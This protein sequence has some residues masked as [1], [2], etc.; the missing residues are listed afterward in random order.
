MIETAT[1][2]EIDK[3]WGN[4]KRL[5]WGAYS[6]SGATFMYAH[7]EVAERL[8]PCNPATVEA[9]SHALD[10]ILVLLDEIDRLKTANDGAP[11]TPQGE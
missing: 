5:E 6:E 8:R 11:K 4:A 1:I 10:D 7:A 3:R 9:Y 2:D